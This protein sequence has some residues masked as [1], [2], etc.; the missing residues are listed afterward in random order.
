VL[1]CLSYGIEPQ[2]R[3]LIHALRR[4]GKR[5]SLPRADRHDRRLHVHP[6]PC[7]LQRLGFGLE[8]PTPTAPAIADAE[9]M[10]ELDVALILGLGFDRAGVRLGHGSGYVDRFLAAHPVLAIGLSFEA[11]LL[12]RL[13]RAPYD[14]PMQVIVSEDRVLRTG[15]P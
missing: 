1:V 4:A 8:Q 15:A 7:E 11:Q 5:V 3:P 9:I 12:E 2:T 13:P 10:R 14:L 6:W